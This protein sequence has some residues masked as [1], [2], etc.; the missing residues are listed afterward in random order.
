MRDFGAFH[1]K[2]SW[3][4][5]LRVSSTEALAQTTFNLLRID[6]LFQRGERIRSHL[7]TLA[8]KT[9]DFSKKSVSFSKNAEK[10]LLKPSLGQETLE[11]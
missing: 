8:L 4:I 7:G 6:A 5:G 9:E 11:K 10:D 2:N 1:K 3:R